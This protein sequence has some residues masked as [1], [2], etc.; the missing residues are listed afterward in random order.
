[1]TSREDLEAAEIVTVEWF[2]FVSMAKI[3][4]KKLNPLLGTTSITMTPYQDTIHPPYPLA[5]EPPPL[6]EHASQAG[7]KGFRHRWEKLAYAFDSPP[8]PPPNFHVCPH[9]P[10]RTA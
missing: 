3:V 9:F 1:M 2:D 5:F 10:T 4:D 8:T 6:I 7:T